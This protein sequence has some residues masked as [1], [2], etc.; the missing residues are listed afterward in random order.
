MNKGFI[1]VYRKIQSHWLYSNNE[2]LACWVKILLNVNHCD[3]TVLLGGQLFNIKRGQSIRSLDQWSDIFGKNWNKSKTR[4]FFELLKKENMIETINEQKT[5][6]LCIVN[7]DIYNTQRNDDETITKRKPTRSR[8]DDETILTPNKNDKEVIKNE[9]EVKKA[10]SIEIAYPD[11]FDDNLKSVFEE[12]LSVRKKLKLINSE[13]VLKRL[14][15][16]LELFSGKNKLHANDVIL[17]AINSAWKDFYALKDSAGNEIIP[18]SNKGNT[19]QKVNYD[20][21]HIKD[22]IKQWRDYKPTDWKKIIVA[23]LCRIYNK[24]IFPVI[25]KQEN[26]KAIDDPEVY[27]NTIVEVLN[28]RL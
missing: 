14:F 3:N 7:F 26:L 11:W 21:I 12:Y 28:E 15:K 16:K 19:N 23:D 18:E 4:R 27:F 25:T 9:K 5:T 2:Y 20:Y 22:N 17:N 6:R 10:T 1:K 24:D 8:N 13:S